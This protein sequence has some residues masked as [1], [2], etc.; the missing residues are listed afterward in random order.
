MLARITH[1]GLLVANQQEALDWYMDKLGFERRSD[2][3]PR[4]KCPGVSLLY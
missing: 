2:S 1:I 4:R 3:V